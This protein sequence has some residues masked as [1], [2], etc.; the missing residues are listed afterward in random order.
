LKA[1]T[2]G[3]DIGDPGWFTGGL[4]GVEQTKNQLPDKFALYQ[5]YPNPFNP[6]T[7]ITFT[8]AQAGNVSLKVYDIMGREVRNVVNNVYKA[9]GTYKYMINMNDMASGVYLY[10]LKQNGNMQT[11]KMMLLK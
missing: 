3:K 9:Q 5:S 10:T 4:T 6:S 1:G 8:L 11:M 2:D 7:T